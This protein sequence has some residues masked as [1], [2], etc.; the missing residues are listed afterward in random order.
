[1]KL[2][3]VF[4]CSPGGGDI[5]VFQHILKLIY[6]TFDFGVNFHHAAL[7]SKKELEKECGKEVK[8]LKS[9]GCQ[10]VFVVW[11]LIPVWKEDGTPCRHDDKEAIK[12]S[13]AAHTLTANDIIFLCVEKELESWLIA[14]E[15]ALKDFFITKNSMK[16]EITRVRTPD[17]HHDPKGLLTKYF[18][19]Y[20]GV[21]SFEPMIHTELLLK[22]Y[23][24]VRNLRRSES[25]KRFY[26]KLTGTALT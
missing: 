21:R 6:P 5:K 11:D 8:R 26:L 13:L 22:K 2:G 4:E 9:L 20:R 10:K 23:N 17:T 1:M 24:N 15:R 16:D 25:F 7:K 14:D 18:K 19:M 3:F 12:K